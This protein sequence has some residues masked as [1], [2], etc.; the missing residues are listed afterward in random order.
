MNPGSSNQTKAVLEHHLKAF[1]AADLEATMADYD[2][3]AVLIHPDGVEQGY[4]QIQTFFEQ[5]YSVFPARASQQMQVE[6]VEGEIAYIIWSGE[7]EQLD[8]RYA[9][10]TFVVR[11]SKITVQTFAGLIDQK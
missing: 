2:E 4:E 5:I 7:S 11:D 8:I 3:N 1:A 10:D 9:T 6:T